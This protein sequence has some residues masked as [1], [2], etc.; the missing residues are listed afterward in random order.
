MSVKGTAPSQRSVIIITHKNGIHLNLPSN[1]YQL[2]SDLIFINLQRAFDWMNHHK[3]WKQTNYK[4]REKFDRVTQSSQ[5]LLNWLLCWNET[6][7]EWTEMKKVLSS[8]LRFADDIFPTT[9]NVASSTLKLLLPFRGRYPRRW[10]DQI[11]DCP[12]CSV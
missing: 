3:M 10:S 11:K 7:L 4:L 12:Q 9:D 8:L 2:V 1:I 5:H 6:L